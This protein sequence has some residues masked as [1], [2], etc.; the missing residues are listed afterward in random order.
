MADTEKKVVLTVDTGN[1][2]KTVKGLKEEIKTLQNTILNLD[3]GTEEYNDAV[4]QLQANQRA[5]NEV[6]GLTRRD[7]VALEGSYDALTYRMAELKKEWKATND[8]A[9]R[10][11][12]GIEINEINAQLKELDASTGNYQRNVGN[13]TEAAENAFANLKQEI[14]DARNELLNAEEGTEEYNK[15]MNRLAD[16]QFQLR[17]MNEQSRYAVADFGEQLSNVTGIASGVVSG[18]SALQAAFVLC[19]AESEN[20]QK[21]M[22]N[23]QAAMALVQGLQGLEG[24]VDRV[25][26]L[27]KALKALSTGSWIGIILTAVAALGALTIKLVQNRRE[28]KSGEKAIKDW[29]KASIEQAKSIAQEVVALRIWESIATDVTQSYKNRVIAAKELLSVIGEQVTQENVLNLMQGE[30]AGKIDGVTEALVRQAIAQAALAQI[31]EKAG[32]LL[33][34]RIEIEQKKKELAEPD[35]KSWIPTGSRGLEP[36]TESGN[37]R[38]N[39]RIEKQIGRLEKERTQLLTDINAIWDTAK[40]MVQ[41]MM[42]ESSSNNP[43]KKELTKTISDLANKEIEEIERVYQYRMAVNATSEKGEKEKARIE[44]A[45]K[46]ELVNKKIAI[47]TKYKDEAIAIQEQEIADDL[48]GEIAKLQIENMQTAYDE[49]M[50]LREL[51]EKAVREQ[52]NNLNFLSDLSYKEQMANLERESITKEE[53]SRKAYEIELAYQEEQKARLQ[54]YHDWLME[55]EEKNHEEIINVKQNLAESELEIANLKKDRE[56]EIAREMVD[57]VIRELDE[58]DDAYDKEQRKLALDV[59]VQDSKKERGFFGTIL[60]FGARDDWKSEEKRQADEN[61]YYQKAY[62][63]EQA[64]L[65]S[66]KALQEE[67][68]AVETDVEARLE[69][70]REIANTEIEIQESKYAEL[71]RLR[72]NDTANEQR[73]QEQMREITM[74]GMDAVS[75]VLGSIA[76]VY[77]ANEESAKE[78][79]EKIKALR[80]SAAVIDTISG[81]IGAY[82]MAAATIPPPAGIIV[83]AVQAA[84]VTAAGVANIAKI[85]N[86]KIGDSNGGGD[87]GAAVTPQSNTYQSELPFSYTRQVTTAK[88]YDELNKDTKVYVVESEI[89]EAQNRRKVR[90]EES[91][92]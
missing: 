89:T 66:K 13:Y 47:L 70:E 50:R 54:E 81:A 34:K 41:E 23:L 46:Q 40:Q 4:R 73:K 85:K 62:E 38:E 61:D 77:E 27:G 19:G 35:K 51:D 49:K 48:S 69:I 55:D 30:L 2:E 65:A 22:V 17:D 12:L 42:V 57:A 9:R 36:V 44:A 72:D 88:E 64:F 74:A 39:K 7:A 59:P 80:I 20:L 71:Q 87:V 92:F 43:D 29:N 58:L 68:L 52:Y 76:D 84:A 63:A 10:N 11:E 56:I 83:G 5:L 33:A 75:S 24:I 28:I 1:A 15:A 18:F 32:E 82:T 45:L 67:Y 26:G 37:E 91:S 14:R 16:A 25:K 60:G 53:K 79:A 3:K 78:N 31:E 6:M 21:T 90:V 8:E 86:T